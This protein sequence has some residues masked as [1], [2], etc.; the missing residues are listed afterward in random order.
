MRYSI[1]SDAAT[2]NIGVAPKSLLPEI[3]RDQSDVSP[4]LFFRQKIAAQN[5]VNAEHIEIV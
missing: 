1:E 4:F 3:F 5:R 2:E